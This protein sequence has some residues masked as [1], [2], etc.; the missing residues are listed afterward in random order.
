MAIN[1]ARYWTAVLYPENMLDD[2]EE[3]VGD[4]VEL[5]YAYCIHDADS[6]SKK[7]EERKVHVHMILVFSNTTTQNH[8]FNVFNQLA[9]PGL[10]ALSACQPVI[11]I[12][13][14]Y[15]Y[16]IHDTDAA[17]KQGKHLYPESSRIT[18]NNF[19]I[20]AYET[21]GIQEKNAMCRELCDCIIVNN[22]KN[23]SDFYIHAIVEYVEKDSNYFEVLKSY[24]SLFEKLTRANYQRSYEG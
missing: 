7:Q 16:L 20:G 22:F 12:R 15:D 11:S 2:W 19:D 4:L 13:G 9:K 5:P 18:G 3:E 21:L 1:K 6:T 24:S 17:R 14:K 23:F 8:A 10:K